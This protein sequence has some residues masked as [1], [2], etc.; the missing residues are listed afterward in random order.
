MYLHLQLTTNDTTHVE[1]RT[2]SLLWVIQTSAATMGICVVVPQK[3][4]NISTV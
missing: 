1:R 2:H 3:A 4:R